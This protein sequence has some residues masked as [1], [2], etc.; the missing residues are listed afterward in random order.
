M[1]DEQTLVTQEPGVIASVDD[2]KLQ[3]IAEMTVGSLADSLVDLSDN[4]LDQLLV[5][6][7]QG[8]ARTTA[9]AA[10]EREQAHREAALESPA[11]AA[12]E[13][14]APVGDP[15]SYANMR[16]SEVDQDSLQG[17]VL[18]LDGWL[19]PRPSAEPQG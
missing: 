19:H 16:A 12:H 18:T 5:L 4:E 6:E 1:S 14:P 13:G 9:I 15:S 7:Q 8:S 2:A 11:N 10:I 3:G 17:P